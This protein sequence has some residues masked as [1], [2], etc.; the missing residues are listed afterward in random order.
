MSKTLPE[1]FTIQDDFPPVDYEAWRS[2]VDAA[3]KGAPFDKKLVTHTY[4][5]IDIQPVYSR[6]DAVGADDPF[7][8]PGL[9]PFVRGSRALGA[10]ATGWDLRQEYAHP[11]LAIANRAIIDDLKGGANS[12]LL[13]WDAAASDGLDPDQDGAA[14]KSGVQGLMLYQIDDLDAL[15]K[16]VRPAN[17]R[18]RAG[19]R[20]GVPTRGG[21]IGRALAKT[22]DTAG[23]RESRIQRGSLFRVGAARPT[24]TA[25]RRVAAV[26]GRIGEVDRRQLP[27]GDLGGRRHFPLS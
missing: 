25:H 27:A 10:A 13:R 7:G 3:L 2:L 11:D 4:D 19:C 21:L 22:R 16:D 26:A 5:G 24:A 6:Q 12:L 17:G 9:P 18:G 8:C 23:R 15:L 1:A 14:E 20:C